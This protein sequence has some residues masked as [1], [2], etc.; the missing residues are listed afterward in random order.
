MV[1]SNFEISA[2]NFKPLRAFDV[3]LPNMCV[4]VCVC[5]FHLTIVF[6]HTDRCGLEMYW[7][8]CLFD[9]RMAIKCFNFKLV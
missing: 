7:D 6:H 5:S 8:S 9:F 1:N 4:F 3:S 2:L